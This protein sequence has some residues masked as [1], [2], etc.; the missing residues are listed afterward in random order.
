MKNSVEEF[1]SRFEHPEESVNLMIGWAIEII[2]SEVQKVK[3]LKKS[4]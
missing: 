4:E 1:K 3:R 2:K